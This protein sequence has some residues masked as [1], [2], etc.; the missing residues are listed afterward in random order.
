MKLN[1]LGILFALLIVS[2]G[3][4]LA[5]DR[6]WRQY[7]GSLFSFRYPGTWELHAQVDR[8]AVVADTGS[9]I[10]VEFA[11]S[12]G[13][14]ASQEQ[15]ALNAE[16]HISQFAR[17][18]NMAARF[19]GWNQTT[20]GAVRVISH[21]CSNLT[22]TDP[23]FCSADDRKAIDVSSIIWGM[24]GRIILIEMMHKPGMSEAQINIGRQIVTTLI[25]KP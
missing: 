4:N 13:Q 10:S 16:K 3:L 11:V 8:D 25:L 24:N 6:S 9:P 18:N 15:L 19:E 12:Q 2:P 20:G 5:Q 1:T 22:S 23:H 14:P 17:L 21:I 7:N